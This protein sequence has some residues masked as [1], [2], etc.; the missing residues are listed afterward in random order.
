M[1]DQ[2]KI[3]NIAPK[4]VYITLEIASSTADRLL[5]GLEMSEINFDGEDSEQV[6]CKEAVLSLYELLSQAVGAVKNVS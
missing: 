3:V 5:K 4:D 1:K 2:M 6:E